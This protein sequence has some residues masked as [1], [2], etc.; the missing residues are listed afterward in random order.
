MTVRSRLALAKDL[1]RL[2]ARRLL[3]SSLITGQLQVQAT[4]Y[5]GRA[6]AVFLPSLRGNAEIRAIDLLEYAPQGAWK[7]SRTLLSAVRAGLA[8]VE[9]E[10]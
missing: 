1:G 4:G 7:N 6:I 8:Q 9:I 5:D 2:Q 10:V 3:A